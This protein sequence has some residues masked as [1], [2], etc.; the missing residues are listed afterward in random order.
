MKKLLSVLTLVVLIVGLA[1]CGNSK[2]TTS[3]GV[4]LFVT[5][6]GEKFISYNESTPWNAPDG[7][8]YNKGDMLP[9]WVQ[10]QE[11]LGIKIIDSTPK[12]SNDADMLLEQAAT[13]GFDSADIYMGSP[14]IISDYG[15]QGNFIALNNYFDQMPNFKKFL[16]ENPV[17]TQ[18]LTQADGNIYMVPYFDDV[19]SIETMFMMRLDWVKKILDVESPT[20]D[21]SKT[22]TPEYTAFY[23]YA[24]G[25]TVNVGVGNE[26]TINIAE[27][28][29]TTQNSNT[30]NGTN[31]AQELRDYIDANYMNNDDVDYTNRS[32]L[33]ISNKAA[34]DA[35][36]LIALMRA[37]KANPVY[38]TGEDKD[39]VIFNARR[40]KDVVKVK[41]L[42]QI[43]GVQGTQSRNETLFLNADNNVIDARHNA[44]FLDAMENMNKLYK[45]GLI[46]EDFDQAMGNITD[47]RKNNFL[48]NNGFLTVD[49]NAS[50][51]ALHDTMDQSDLES[52]GT[53]V[54]AVLPAAAQWFNDD[55]VSY[56]EAIR[57][58]KTEG[59][60]GVA[61]HVN[62]QT[63]KDA[64]KLMDYPFTDAGSDLFSFG[65]QGLYWNEKISIGGVEY[66]KLTDNFNQDVV[67]YTT[68][69]W[70]NFMR[71]YVGATLGIGFVKNTLA[72]EYQ[73][74]NEHYQNGLNRLADSA[75]ILASLSDD[76]APQKR[77]LPTIFPLNEDEITVLE[78]A[79][80]GTYFEEWE[81]RIIKYGFGGLIATSDSTVPTRTEFLDQLEEKGISQN[82]TIK[83]NAYHRSNEE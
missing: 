75:L 27:N 83:N 63:L 57:S 25:K 28:I 59:G 52:F 24:G 5:Y 34:Y 36:E 38:L 44:K 62:G 14:R 19:N 31:L 72:L 32:D 54:E 55:F 15:T 16:D 10:V 47:F 61:S 9:T 67:T 17:V 79:T 21:T 23:D 51:T 74:G 26:V 73:I 43:W 60:W 29:I 22:I 69:N 7:K 77:V 46:L 8:T 39:L 37:V 30:M 40:S 4:R 41:W 2:K 81:S 49:Y 70:S 76:V 45:E 11:D 53:E 1:A 82:E 42:A 66:P 58:V 50:T 20:F 18:T 64:L 3:D 6:D 65:P 13:T 33:F 68:G 71:G 48:T 78:T 56:T 35:D 80:Y 12:S